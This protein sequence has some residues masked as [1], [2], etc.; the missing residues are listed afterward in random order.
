MKWRYP[1]F[2]S[3]P[4]TVHDTPGCL[5]GGNEHHAAVA[6]IRAVALVG[7]K[8]PTKFRHRHNNN[9]MQPVLQVEVEGCKTA[10][11]L[12]DEGSKSPGLVLVRVPTPDSGSGRAWRDAFAVSF[13]L[14]RAKPC[15]LG[16]G[17]CQ[18]VSPP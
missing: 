13:P 18:P 10:R 8:S 6:V 3:G 12:A 11:E 2:E 17:V 14:K 7:A 9:A 15:D 1:R 4:A 5:R 16:P